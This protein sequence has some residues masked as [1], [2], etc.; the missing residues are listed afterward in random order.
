VRDH[1]TP[2]SGLVVQGANGHFFFLTN[3]EYVSN[4]NGQNGD[5]SITHA[6]TALCFMAGTSI[7][8][9]DGDFAVEGL[10][11]GDRVLTQA[12]DVANAATLDGLFEALV[13]SPPM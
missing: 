1:G 6:H 13:I 4:L 8:T 2:I 12:W 10:K 5:L 11:R 9:P 7:R 3:D